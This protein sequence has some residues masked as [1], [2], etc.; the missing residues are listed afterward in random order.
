MSNSALRAVAIVAIVS[1]IPFR[2][3]ADDVAPA[4]A[5]SALPQPT[6]SLSLDLKG[7]LELARRSAPELA[8]RRARVAEAESLRAGAGVYPATNPVVDA[9]LGPRI[10]GTDRTAVVGVGL[11]QTFELGPRVSARLRAVD[12]AVEAAG[13]DSDAAAL[14]LSREVATAFARALW[15]RERL[16][17]ATDV[18]A[19]ATKAA[20]S[21]GRRAQA[22]ETSGLE[23]NVARG[24]LARARADRKSLQARETAALAQLKLLLGLPHGTHLEPRGALD[25]LSVPGQAALL[26]ATSKHPALRAA[27]ADLAEARAEEDLGD[28][29]AYPELGVGVRYENED[30]NVHTV[31][32]TF[33]VS[34]PIFEHGQGVSSRARAKRARA[35]SELALRTQRLDSTVR[36]SLEVLGMQRDAAHAFD[37]E[38]GVEAFRDNVKLATK[39]FDA[40]ETD[41]TSLLLLRR[42]LIDT[43]AE[44]IDRLLELRLAEIDLLHAS[45]VLQ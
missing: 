35:E 3:F 2:A 45:G 40:G 25:D 13:A 36:A 22:G 38:G 29:L 24:A 19:I 20:E 39:G 23:L 7:A 33:S 26:A 41:L 43:E 5:P 18:E 10:V 1:A 42:E 34:V 27:R 30:R 6:D 16:T 4:A 14:D 12:A 15:A 21:A 31:L 11:S 17:L 44:R 32:G 28:A 8:V 9:A 37:S